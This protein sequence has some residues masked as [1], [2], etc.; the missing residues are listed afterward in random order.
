MNL[1]R[2]LLVLSLPLYVL[3]QATKFW[4]VFKFDPH[5]AGRP[6]DSFAIIP[7]WFD[8]VRVHNQGVAF[9]LGNGTSWAP[10]VFLIVPLI[11]LV[12]LRV[13]WVKGFLEGLMSR[14]A[15]ALL[16]CGIFGNLT[17]RLIQGFLLEAYKGASFW[18]RLSEGYVVDFVS[19]KLP[20]YDKIFPKS[21]GWWPAFNVADSCI[22]IA[23]VLIFISGMREEVKDKKEKSDGAGDKSED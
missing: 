9:G 18:T 6:V 3:D 10:V 15:V 16:L 19:V 2:L 5:I 23:A 1:P 12:L 21:G 14:I 17:D 4:T 13:L 7:G 8:W 22:C 20:L 11:A